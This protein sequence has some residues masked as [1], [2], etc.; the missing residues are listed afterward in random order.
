MEGRNH[1]VISASDSVTNAGGKES[2]GE[3]EDIK[4]RALKRTK[5]NTKSRYGE[6]LWT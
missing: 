5:K 1:K 3:G 4:H 2:E 6:F